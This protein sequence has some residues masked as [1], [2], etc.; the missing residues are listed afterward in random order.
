MRRGDF[1]LAF[2]EFSA[3]I[4]LNAPQNRYTNL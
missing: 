4:K 3:A 2:E 1:D